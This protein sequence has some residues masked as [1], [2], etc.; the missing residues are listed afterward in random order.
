MYK[1]RG[2]KLTQVG[3]KHKIKEEKMIDPISTL[4][5]SCALVKNGK[6]LVKKHCPSGAQK[7]LLRLAA[8]SGEFHILNIDQLAYPIVR[9]GGVD[10]GD[11]SDPTSLAKYYEAFGQLC[12]NGYIE[13]ASGKLF[14]LTADGFEKARNL[15]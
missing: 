7:E 13:F 5:D 9:A 11:E 15:K 14:R 1:D 12:E 8:Q 3:Y 10:L 4:K 2:S 6:D